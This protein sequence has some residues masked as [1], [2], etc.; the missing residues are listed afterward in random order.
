MSTQICPAI[1]KMMKPPKFAL[2]L[3]ILI[4]GGICNPDT[5]G[6]SFTYHWEIDETPEGSESATIVE[7]IE[8]TM[9]DEPIQVVS[10][11]ASLALMRKYS[12]YL[13]PEWSPGHAYRLLQTFESIPQESNRAGY[14]VRD[15][16]P[17]IWR[18]SDLHIQDDIE[19][20]SEGEAKIV[21]ISKYAFSYAEPLLAEI[22][23]VRG[24]FFSKRL[25]RAIVRYVSNH[26]EDVSA[27]NRILY[28]R[29]N[30]SVE[31]PD[32]QQLTGE[33]ASHFQMFTSDELIA[34]TS[35]FEEFP[36]GMLKIQ[37]LNYLVR[38]LRGTVNPQTPWAA[39]LAAIDKGYIE[40]MDSAFGAGPAYIHRVILHEKAHFL[41][42][43]LFDDQLKQ[44]W[45]TLGGWYED[46]EAKSGWSTTKEVEFVSGYAHGVNPNEDMAESIS[47]Y[48]VNPDKL[49]SRAPA[50]YEF[51][52][53]RI[54]HG[55]R[56]ISK[57]RE[58]L[59]FRVYNLYP[60][61]V[62]P[63]RI[64]RV[65]IRVQ[66]KLEEDKQITIE[67]E[68]HG[69][70][71]LDMSHSV[72]LHIFSEHGHRLQVWLNPMDDNGQRVTSSHALR[73][74]VTLSRYAANGYYEPEGIHLTD[75]AGNFRYIS[76]SN[77]GWKLY[78]NNPLEDL[79][80]PIYVKD[81]MNLSLSN[82]HEDGRS[83]QIVTAS[84]KMIDENSGI[85][86]Q[87][88]SRLLHENREISGIESYGEYNS[89]TGQAKVNFIFPDYRIGG[90]Y[91]LTHVRVSDIAGNIAYINFGK[92]TELG[93]EAKKIN[94]ET[95]N[96]DTTKPILDLNRIRVTA[97]P[98]RPQDP[99]GETRVDLYYRVKDDISGYTGGYMNVRDPLGSEY[100]FYLS[101]PG[102]Y[103]LYFVGDPT[104]YKQYHQTIVL[105]AGSVP[106]IWGITEMRLVDGAGNG[107]L[108]DFTEIVRFEVEEGAAAAPITASLPD[109]TQL[110]ANYPNPFNPETWIPYQLATDSDVQISIY[111]T[112]G[113][114][115][116][117]LALGHQASGYYT[118][119]SRAAYWDGRN[120][121][122]ER[123]ASGVY[124]YQLQTNEIS[125]MRKMVIL[126]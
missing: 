113:I 38:R 39:A 60:D 111:D 21:T 73:G 53:N 11:S 88:Y 98:T 75:S 14:E 26:G 110:L 57:I 69:E 106:G 3:V 97:E 96:P 35:M 122:G 52:Q 104:V 83:Y 85:A 92:D 125:F 95:K 103:K 56:Y 70:S 46:P 109:N 100:G 42:A 15:V 82:G 9:L 89:E 24:R 55:T 112:K 105:P 126:K 32:Y 76:R 120:G 93:E 27:I 29:Y 41:W 47:F 31:I 114:V 7:P 44:D 71:E 6:E 8:V 72:S 63:G 101:T 51:I 5:Y 68:I 123:V 2:I 33:P 119:R 34:I 50:K 65:D 124:F 43:Y 74:I 90:I 58:D 40:F 81:S 116:R 118:D 25:H 115:V 19:I 80:A 18:L 16:P 49:R 59:T 23:G 64:V 86:T 91:E 94:I 13:G 99:N 61:Y 20:S 12:V 37:G 28:G 121:L 67:I 66:G 62:Y 17:S 77:F 108:V 107:L 84:W 22:E 78:I 54:M 79:E 117:T 45:I 87:V 48:I 4:V 102:P 10:H 30:V 1:K 36:S